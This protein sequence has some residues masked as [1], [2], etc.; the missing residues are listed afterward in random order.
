MSNRINTATT[1]QPM[2]NSAVNV[3]TTSTS[4]SHIAK[5]NTQE[6][7]VSDDVGLRLVDT[8]RSQ[9]KLSFNKSLD[10]VRVMLTSLG[11][12]IPDINT[13]METVNEQIRDD[14]LVARRGSAAN[15]DA[16]R[17]REVLDRLTEH[18]EDSQQRNWA[19]HE[20]FEVI[21]GLLDSLLKTLSEIDG[22]IVRGVLRADEYRYIN[23]LIV[24]FQMEHR[25][26]LRVSMLY[27]FGK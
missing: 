23:D 27:V 16:D 10:V 22:N 8:V 19:V 1:T 2:S 4:S 5:P 11:S 25:S 9:C 18:K 20:D 3:S 7:K 14:K 12:E 21:K 17:L 6:I 15:E 26:A 24:Y 13:L